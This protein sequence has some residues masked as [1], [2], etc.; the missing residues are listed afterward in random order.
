M[1]ARQSADVENQMVSVE[2]ILEYSQLQ[3]EDFESG[4]SEVK[5]GAPI[6]FSNVSVTYNDMEVLKNV[7]FT[8]QK[9]EK[10]SFFCQPMSNRKYYSDNPHSLKSYIN[11]SLL[12]GGSA[13]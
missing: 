1:G 10:V 6:E 9:G 12:Q 2:R 5:V 8:V 11:L 7:S 4:D 3:I 13:W